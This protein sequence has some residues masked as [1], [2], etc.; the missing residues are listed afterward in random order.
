MSVHASGPTPA[1][2]TKSKPQEAY[3][4]LSR[5]LPS[6]PLSRSFFWRISFP[7]APGQNPPVFRPVD[8]RP[9]RPAFL[10]RA[11]LSEMR[12]F[13][14]P[15]SLL[16]NRIVNDDDIGAATGEGASDRPGH[17]I[18]Q[19]LGSF[20]CPPV[21]GSGGKPYYGIPSRHCRK[22]ECVRGCSTLL[23]EPR[24]RSGSRFVSKH[25]CVVRPIY[26]ARLHCGK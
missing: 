17:S 7:S 25:H 14:A 21:G 10:E 2:L 19:T 8:A 26:R 1:I 5:I 11:S 15:N 16:V 13:R 3:F 12:R 18:G 9:F 22:L 24:R 4:S 23:P 20:G 6:P